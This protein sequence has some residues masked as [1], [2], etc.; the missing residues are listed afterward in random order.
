MINDRAAKIVFVL[1][2]T[3][4]M[5]PTAALALDTDASGPAEGSRSTYTWVGCG[6]G[7]SSMGSPGGHFNI[8]RTSGILFFGFR[9]TA[10]SGGKYMVVDRDNDYDTM[11]DLALLVGLTRRCGR[12]IM[13]ASTGVAGVGGTFHEK[14]PANSD[15]LIKRDYQMVFGLPFEAQLIWRLGDNV[16]LGLYGYANVNSNRNHGG[17]CISLVFGKI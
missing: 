11:G 9:T 3:V 12:F 10:S 15:I 8:S 14:D 17:L 6:I 4:M 13:S 5:L 16:G 2:L 1:F 7:A